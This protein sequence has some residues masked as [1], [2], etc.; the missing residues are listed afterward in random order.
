[1]NDE[2]D[3]TPGWFFGL[4]WIFVPNYPIYQVVKKVADEHSCID[5]ISQYM[6]LFGIVT[7]VIVLIGLFYKKSLAPLLGH[8][9]LHCA[10]TLVVF[11]GA[12]FVHE[13][14]WWMTPAIA[15]NWYFYWNL[16]FS[17]PVFF[18]LV[19]VANLYLV[20]SS[21]SIVD[22]PFGKKKTH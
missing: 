13:F 15:S 17:V 21:D 7:D 11:A 9:V 4:Q 10:I 1:M 6:F 22:S 20:F 12:A 19:A 5:E 8:L 16:Y 2:I 14:I 3:E 18:V